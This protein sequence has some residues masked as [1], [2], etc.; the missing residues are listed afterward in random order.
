VPWV[1]RSE[2]LAHPRDATLARV[3]GSL[4][5]TIAQPSLEVLTEV[6]TRFVLG[7]P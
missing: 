5:W 7:R 2:K 1:A 4:S 6:N 3:L